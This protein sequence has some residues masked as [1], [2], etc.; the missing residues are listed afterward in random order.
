MSGLSDYASAF[1]TPSQTPSRVGKVKGNILQNEWNQIH[2][3]FVWSYKQTEFPV[4]T[5]NKTCFDFS[6]ACVEWTPDINGNDI[7]AS[8]NGASQLI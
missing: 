2:C 5:S 7:A 3:L 1:V 6:H 8:G 4:N